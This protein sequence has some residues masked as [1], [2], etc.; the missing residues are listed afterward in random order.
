[1]YFLIFL[2][3]CFCD[4]DKNIDENYR[5]VFKVKAALVYQGF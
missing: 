1:M 5:T 4:R 2:K 3:K